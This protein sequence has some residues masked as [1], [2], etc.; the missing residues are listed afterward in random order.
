M[1]YNKLKFQIALLCEYRGD[2]H[3]ERV[4]GLKQVKS[5]VHLCSLKKNKTL[6]VLVL[7]QC[8]FLYREDL[9]NIVSAEPVPDYCH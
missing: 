2:V 3:L 4:E 9:L 7:E 6:F 5:P 8:W 1:P